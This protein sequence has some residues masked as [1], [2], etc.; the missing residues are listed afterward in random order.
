LRS[1]GLDWDWAELPAIDV[2]VNGTSPIEIDVIGPSADS[3]A[4][5]NAAE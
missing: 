4:G 2:D 1:I 5:M 3:A